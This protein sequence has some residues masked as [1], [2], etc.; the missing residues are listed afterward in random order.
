M[1]LQD[2]HRRP[3]LQASFGNA[4]NRNHEKDRL[5]FEETADA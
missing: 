3:A 2:Q 5:K 1:M 4:S